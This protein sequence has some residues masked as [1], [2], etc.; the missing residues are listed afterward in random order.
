MSRYEQR[1][2]NVGHRSALAGLDPLPPPRKAA[3]ARQAYE[4]GYCAGAY[5]LASHKLKRMP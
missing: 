3:K 2:F 4:S 5:V 1:W